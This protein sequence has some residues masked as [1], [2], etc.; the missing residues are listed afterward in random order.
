MAAESTRSL[1]EDRR[2]DVRSSSAMGELATLM[3]E[4]DIAEKGEPSFTIAAGKRKSVSARDEVKTSTIEGEIGG[5]HSQSDVTRHFLPPEIL[6]HLVD[7]FTMHFNTFH[8]FL[9]INDVVELKSFGI[10]VS[11]L[12]L[13][14]RNAALLSVAACL[15]SMPEAKR[16]RST[17]ASLADGL[18][19]RCIKERPNDIVVQGLTLLAW[20]ELMFGVPSLAYN[21]IGMNFF[22]HSDMIVRL[23]R[24]SNGDWTN[25]TPGPPRHCSHEESRWFKRRASTLQAPY[26][27]I[28][29]VFLC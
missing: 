22:P 16:T 11:T 26:S 21:Y 7:C 3:L 15:S 25:F 6:D 29:G 8:Q 9:D 27:V 13:R 19:L 4:M 14:F 5:E 18:A 24:Q 17:Y 20:K 23:K 10:N 28:L 2:D 1:A 12:D